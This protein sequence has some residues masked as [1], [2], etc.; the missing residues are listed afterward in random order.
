MAHGLARLGSARLG[1]T[2]LDSA[3]L[4]HGSHL[5]R[6]KP[7]EGRGLIDHAFDFRERFTCRPPLEIDIRRRPKNPR[8]GLSRCFSSVLMCSETTVIFVRQKRVLKACREAF[9][10]IETR[11]ESLVMKASTNVRECPDLSRRLLKCARRAE[12][13]LH[14]SASPSPIF[15][16]MKGQVSYPLFCMVESH[17]Y[18]HAGPSPVFTVLQ[19]R[20]LSSLFCRAESHLHYFVGPSP[21]FTFLQGR[22]PSSSLLFCR[23][24]SHNYYFAGSSLIFTFLQDRVL[25][26]LL[27]CRVESYNYSYVGSSLVFTIPQDQDR[28]PSSLF[29]RVESH[30]YSYATPSLT[31]FPK[32]GPNVRING[33]IKI[34]TA[35]AE[36]KTGILLKIFGRILYSSTQPKRGKLSA[37]RFGPLTPEEQKTRRSPGGARRRLPR[38][39]TLLPRRLEV[40]TAVH[41]AGVLPSA[42]RCLLRSSSLSRARPIFLRFAQ[43]Q[44]SR[45]DPAHSAQFS[46][47]QPSRVDS[48]CAV[49]PGTQPGKHGSRRAARSGPAVPFRGP[50]PA[51]PAQFIGLAP[52]QP[53]CTVQTAS[54]LV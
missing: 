11:P 46:P 36:T 33:A 15:T 6:K 39:L 13:P 51:R 28:V 42:H 40:G 29:R 50:T 7:E 21:I 27:F 48:T 9:V 32:Q 35:I 22:V 25:S 12:S 44:P 23:A 1:S 19:G 26:L 2:R 52:V 38:P 34:S 43:V 20:V 16:L 53:V 37:P 45:F 5:I 4:A 54:S 41:S 17:L 3:R 30:L 8:T 14:F 31:V 47:V 10:T 18:S 49:S 24:E